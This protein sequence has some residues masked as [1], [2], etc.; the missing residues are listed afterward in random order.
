M[1]QEAKAK[2]IKIASIAVFLVVLLSLGAAVGAA[3]LNTNR[4]TRPV[5]ERAKSSLEY[6]DAYQELCT[7]GDYKYLFLE[8]K[9][10][11]VIENVNKN[12]PQYGWIW[13]TG[14]DIPQTDDVYDGRKYFDKV[15]EQLIS[16][17]KSSGIKTG[18]KTDD[19]VMAEVLKRVEAGTL[20]INSD[21]YKN[22]EEHAQKNGMTPSQL[23]EYVSASD[24][25]FQSEEWIDFAN[26]LI[27]LNYY[28]GSGDSIQ[29]K[30][31]SSAPSEGDKSA[32][33]VVDEAKHRFKLQ[34]EFSVGNSS[35]EIVGM[36]VYLTFEDNGKV[37]IN[38]PNKEISGQTNKI[39]NVEIAP[40]LGASGGILNY[41]DGKDY[42]IAQKKD[43]VPGYV[44][45]PD[46]SGSLVRFAENTA[47]FQ[48]Y[49]GKVYG[50]D[51]STAQ[52]YYSPANNDVSLN[53]VPIK[54]PTMPV[55]GISQG[56]GTQAAFVAYADS[57]DEYMTINVTPSSM[58]KNKV[59][60][61]YAY[62]SFLYNSEYY[63]VTNQ[64]GA[65]YRKIQDKMNDFDIDMTFQFLDGDGSD[66]T[67]SADYAGMA[68][69]YRQHLIEEGQ[70]TEI[71]EEGSAI[72]IRIDFL[73][74]DSKK[75]VF[76]TQE[77]AVTTTDDVRNIL[78]SLNNN[79]VHN[80]NAG[81][82]G[83]QSGG[84][85][86]AKPYSTSFSGSVGSESD[87]EELMKDFDKRGIDISFS[88]DFTMINEDMI[89]YYNNAAKHLNTQY[90]TLDR[91]EILP[92]NCPVTEY[93]Y[94]RPEKSA[95]WIG[96]LYEDVG[97]YSKSFTLDGV[98]N[99]LLSSYTSDV[100]TRTTAMDTVKLYQDAIGNIK[101]NGT[102]V[103]L[104]NPNKYLWQYTDRY[105]QSPVGT[106]QYVYETD[107]V[108][109]LQMVLSGTMEVYAPYANFSFYSQ[110]DMLRMIDYNT[111][112]SFVLTQE[113]SYLLAATASSDYYSTEYE[114]YK[115]LIKTIYN[116]VNTPLSQVIGYQWDSRT[117]YTWNGSRLVTRHDDGENEQIGGV[118]ANQYT[119]G[120][121]V[122]TI[123][124]NYTDEE[125]Q[126]NG[127]TIA[128]KSAAVIEGGVK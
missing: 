26:S 8:D 106:S 10:I 103:N 91:S 9:D 55:Y 125:I 54:S 117:V 126:V 5:P 123:I 30:R 98:S 121:S 17:A 52:N 76:S 94:A 83:W 114:Q 7:V 96:D 110:T 73:M 120:D 72:P 16:L 34:C 67:P 84:E 124:I 19:E 14:L 128:A 3:F 61:T 48:S 12:S 4:D 71:K 107:T 24:S 95:A 64:A 62:A 11:L 97:E 78:D 15:S 22:L 36:N 37:N 42:T 90:L 86:Q 43:L 99:I 20:E 108:P 115:D 69:A 81:L 127:T 65:A 31:V 58:E 33:K 79:G 25:S 75:G 112:P 74:S 6:T 49:E 59:A 18:K 1:L 77:V 47:T 111:S 104:V 89:S 93:G 46:G 53:V 113:P 27:T 51:P 82:I 35:E 119:K 21:E 105:L 60:Y 2:K 50:S 88:R 39:K 44:L 38:I 66:G 122:K 13:K 41:Y 118:I 80:I 56:D 92:T 40:F 23:L 32:L 57:G 29:P 101:K 109:F 100:N 85:T 70:L 28:E 68:K 116:T 87:F 102:K 63:Q 45:V